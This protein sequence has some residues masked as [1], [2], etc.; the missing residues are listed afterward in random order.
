MGF[1]LIV[2]KKGNIY[3]L[4]L[5]I[6]G[7]SIKMVNYKLVKTTIYAI[8]LAQVII[9]VLVRQHGLPESIVSN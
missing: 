1:Q 2:D 5:I 3:D 8:R 9:N 6:I 4:I 7:Y